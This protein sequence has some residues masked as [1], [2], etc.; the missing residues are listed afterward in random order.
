MPLKVVSFS[1]ITRA[2]ASSGLTAVS[3]QGAP[4]CGPPSDDRLLMSLARHEGVDW[5]L[6]FK[7]F[8]VSSKL[9]KEESEAERITRQAIG[10]CI[11]DSDL[12]LRRPSGIA[13]KCNTTP[14]GQELLRDIH[15]GQC[16]HHSSAGTLVGKAYHSGFYWPSALSDAAEMV[17]RCEAC[18]FHAKQIH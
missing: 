7:A 2:R 18:Q 8:L 13:L 1:T 11:K 3:E 16:A 5:I 10:Y 6:E 15:A 12:Y 17:K 4:D 14:E 9:P